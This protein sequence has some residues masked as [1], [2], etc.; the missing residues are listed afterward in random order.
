MRKL[1]IYSIFVLEMSVLCGCAT[2]HKSDKTLTM[3]D[4]HSNKLPIVTTYDSMVSTFGTPTKN[5]VKMNYRLVSKR[6]DSTRKCSFEEIHFPDQ[7]MAYLRVGD[8]VELSYVFF[9][10][11]R[12]HDTIYCKKRHFCKTTSMDDVAD[13]FGIDS[14]KREEAFRKMDD[15]DFLSEAASFSFMYFGESNEGC[16]YVE[17]FFGDD[18]FL[19]GICFSQPE[20]SIV[21]R[22]EK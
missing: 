10:G 7:N 12:L 6:Q 22:N 19:M 18:G 16:G 15:A 17:F 1:T 4:F 21:Y 5:N 14:A 2:T 13:C 9:D 8:S 3:R 11:P 20:G